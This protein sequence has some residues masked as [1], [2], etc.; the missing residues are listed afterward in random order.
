VTLRVALDATPLLDPPTGVGALTRA[1]LSGLAVR[2]EVDP[3]AFAVTWRGRDRLRASVPT[4]VDVVTR[5]MPARPLRALWRRMDR[6][7][8]EA[9][10]GAVDVVHGPNFVVP[11]S[12]GARLVTVHDL[13]AVRFPELC[14]P[15][16]LQW[17][18]LLRRAVAAGAW[19][20]T[21]SEA[22][23]EEVRNH[24][25]VRPQ[26][27]VVVPNGVDVVLPA[28]EGA[29]AALAGH[30]RYVLAVGTLEP[31][32]DF[33]ALVRAFAPLAAADPE[34]G[35]VLAGADGW[36]A[37]AVH[38][39]VE[40]SPH[41]DRIRR[42]GW[43]TDA[44]RAALLRGAAVLAFPSR[45]EGFGL[46]PLEAMSVGVPVVATA[47]GAIPEVVGDAAVL[48]TPGDED[49]LAEGLR[50]VLDDDTRRTELVERGRQRAAR[51][52]WDATV[53]GLLALYQRMAGRGDP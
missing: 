37:D 42:T 47:T 28:A 30:Q 14:T 9:W 53:D 43:V 7:R 33:P 26:R 17:P 22:V 18:D 20:H 25:G 35:L 41:G 44:D 32:K 45:Y 2:P 39:A 3:V 38:A 6:P 5:P 51:Y 13:T 50:S 31:R 19:V 27:V 49:G 16:V 8:V 36:G 40:A 21:P 1:L 48:V 34:L 29:G 52:S 11:P 15:D 23:A 10:T 12:R 24:F 46:P 4:G